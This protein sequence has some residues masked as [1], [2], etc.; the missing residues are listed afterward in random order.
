[1]QLASL[2]SRMSARWDPD[3]LVVV[4]PINDHIARF[5]A[6]NPIENKAVRYHFSQTMQK[7]MNGP[8]SSRTDRSLAEVIV[9]AVNRPYEDGICPTEPKRRPLDS[10]AAERAQRGSG[11]ELDSAEKEGN[12]QAWRSVLRGR[13]K[14]KQRARASRGWG[15]AKEDFGSSRVSSP[16]LSALRHKPH[17][18]NTV[19]SVL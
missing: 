10:A 18:L 3:T 2:A 16:P 14:K 7:G 13:I 15:D 4:V 11:M 5:F 6:G 12:S 19:K 8:V 17:L 1:M 9:P